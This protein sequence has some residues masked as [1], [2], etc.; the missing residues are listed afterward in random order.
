MTSGSE[1]FLSP[2]TTAPQGGRRNAVTADRAEP[3]NDSEKYDV[4]SSKDGFKDHLTRE[5]NREKPAVKQK[6]DSPAPPETNMNIVEDQTASRVENDP[7]DAQQVTFMAG[8][9]LQG[10]N[11]TGQTR[12]NNYQAGANDRLLNEKNFPPQLNP[13]EQS[14]PPVEKTSDRM[15]QG[16]NIAAITNGKLESPAI[17]IVSPNQATEAPVRENM[18][19]QPAGPAITPS[20]PAQQPEGE[21]FSAKP[22]VTGEKTAQDITGQ[23]QKNNPGA[24]NISQNTL[25]PDSL[26]PDLLT[27][28]SGNKATGANPPAD[29]VQNQR[30]DPHIAGTTV[31]SP[32]HIS[33]ENSKTAKD[34]TGKS[35]KAAGA[36]MN[37][38]AGDGKRTASSDQNGNAKGGS[39]NSAEGQYTPQQTTKNTPASGNNQNSILFRNTLLPKAPLLTELNPL[40]TGTDGK[41]AP[42]GTINLQSG[43]LSVQEAGQG[44]S[45]TTTGHIKPALLP[46]HP[47]Q[48]ITKQISMAIMKQ[49]ANGQDSF[50][51]SLKP[52]E[53]GQ[54][55]IRMDFQADGKMAATIIV[56]NERTLGLLQRDQ[57]ALSKILE[58]AGFDVADNGLNFGLKKHQQDHSHPEFAD[59]NAMTGDNDDLPGPL[60]NIIGRQHM[61]MTYSDNILDI[62]I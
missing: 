42:S 16:Q 59:H 27:L 8:E 44:S 24:K 36:D 33:S 53:L 54:V 52:A 48:I 3:G 18:A 55:N 41:A 37:M 56:D 4:N 50:R 7:S 46:P 45:L 43:I 40:I 9:K 29:I 34:I 2:S 38:V 11:G 25:A 10:L 19:P 49:A 28:D 6:Q 30:I 17:N 58:N 21:E 62:N 61:K 31:Q 12:E 47:Q 23:G 1:L 32:A 35:V 60:D 5:T 51:L 14:A 15:I 20:A 26:T 57:N 39:K 22:V 13:L